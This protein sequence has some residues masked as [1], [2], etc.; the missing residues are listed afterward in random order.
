MNQWGKGPPVSD[1]LSS[2]KLEAQHALM[3]L[4]KYSLTVPEDELFPA[5]RP[6]EKEKK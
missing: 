1:I 4:G 6:L 3:D 5:R 2:E